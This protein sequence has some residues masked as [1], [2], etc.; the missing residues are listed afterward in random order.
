MRFVPALVLLFQFVS[1]LAHGQTVAQSS[2]QSPAFTRL[3]SEFDD[4]MSKY[5][6]DGKAY[7]DA[8]TV[9]LDETKTAKKSLESARTEEEKAAAR[10]KVDAIAKKSAQPIFRPE[11]PEVKF[12]VRFLE[13]AEQHPRDSSAL[14][15]IVRALGAS[16]GP[17]GKGDTWNAAIK[18]LRANYVANPQI[19]KSLC[20]LGMY[21]DVHSEELLRE[22]ITHNPSRKVQALAC[23]TLARGLEDA[24]RYLDGFDGTRGRREYVEAMVG[25]ERAEEIIANAAKARKQAKE[26]STLLKDKYA[27][28]FPDLAIGKSFPDIVSQDLAGK[29]V[30]LRDLRGKIVVLDIWTTWCGPC[31]AMIPHER[32]MTQRL[33]GKPFVLVSISID[34]RKR[35]LV[36]FLGKQAMPWT[37]WWDGQEGAIAQ[38][39]DILR[40]PTIYVL[41]EQGI[42]RHKDIRGEELEAAVN[43]L[44]KR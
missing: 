25:K 18:L 12:S 38:D 1:S 11:N 7:R 16:E 37:H 26:I 41:D 9:L 3:M 13:F 33:K 24:A 22:I 36:D 6:V 21:P 40:I 10:K 20:W 42:I 23:R 19:R 43:E 28:V 39:L 29:R 30:T 17:S 2:A 35:T 8:K 32:E 44:I 4:A 27:D 5:L 31:R 15:S 34:Q 14:D